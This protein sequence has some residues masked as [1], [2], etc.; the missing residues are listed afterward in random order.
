MFAFLIGG[1]TVDP[2]K[3]IVC[4][5]EDVTLADIRKAIYELGYVTYDEVKRYTRAGMGPCGGKT[6]RP[7]ILRELARYWNTTPDKVITRPTTIRPPLKS[8]TFTS[9]AE[10]DSHE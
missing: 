3:I 7:I 10:V 2:E 8:I 6:C 1:D 5:C 4:R 9:A